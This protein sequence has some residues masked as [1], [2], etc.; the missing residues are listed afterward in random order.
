MAA[1]VLG[2]ATTAQQITE[3]LEH[4]IAAGD[5]I[6]I[7]TAGDPPLITSPIGITVPIDEV[8][9][10]TIAEV[11]RK[12]LR[13]HPDAVTWFDYSTSPPTLHIAQR[14]ALPAATFNISTKPLSAV[15]ID[16][17]DDLVLDA[18][19]L[20]FEILS[21]PGGVQHQYIQTDYFPAESTALG[22][23][24]ATIDLK[25]FSSS[26][27]TGDIECA[28]IDVSSLAW[29][30]SHFSYLAEDNSRLLSLELVSAGGRP[31]GSEDYPSELT[32]GQLAEWMEYGGRQEKLMAI[33]TMEVEDPTTHAKEKRTQNISLDITATDAPAGTHHLTTLASY[34]A[35]DPVP[36]GLAE[37]FYNALKD[38]QYSGSVELT[39]QEVDTALRA[40]DITDRTG[41]GLVFNLTGG[42][43]AGA[44]WATMRAMVQEANFDV[45]TGRTVFTFGPPRHLG[46]DDMIEL[47]MVTRRRMIYTNPAARGGTISGGSQIQ[48]GKDLAATNTD[49]GA[50]APQYQKVSGG[51]G[52]YIETDPVGDKP[53]APV[54]SHKMVVG[55][56]VSQT[57][58]SAT[59]ARSKLTLGDAIIDHNTADCVGWDKIKREI[60][61]REIDFCKGD[62]LMKIL[63]DCSEPYAAPPPA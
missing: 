43:G 1:G 21:E 16:R 60:K 58:V 15:N 24:K 62:V 46:I 8:R 7:G 19:M 55:D 39:E 51:G 3:A 37:A 63:V 53:T 59:A 36:V 17:R 50:A 18:V 26:Y 45:D 35:G 42:A 20:K 12:E 30:R 49:G 13:W 54:P 10:I 31:A 33:V 52:A 14:P 5:P 25:G 11:I 29:W 38:V 56:T 57:T 2:Y 4:S 41:V 9:D 32:R 22:V 47:L 61:I 23:F 40:Q 44:E 27:I 34:T 6:Q 28:A 48:L